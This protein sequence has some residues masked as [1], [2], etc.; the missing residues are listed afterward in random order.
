M[1]IYIAGN[2]NDALTIN[3]NINVNTRKGSAAGL[4]TDRGDYNRIIFT[5]NPIAS[6]ANNM[7]NSEIIGIV[8]RNTWNNTINYRFNNNETGMQFANASPNN[9]R[10]MVGFFVIPEILPTKIGTWTE[11]ATAP[12][13]NNDDREILHRLIEIVVEDDN[14]T[15]SSTIFNIAGNSLQFKYT[16]NDRTY[17]PAYPS[18]K[19]IRIFEGYGNTSTQPP[20]ALTPYIDEEQINSYY[21][22]QLNSVTSIG[23]TPANANS[24]DIAEASQIIIAQNTVGKITSVRNGRWSDPQTWDAGSQ[25]TILDTAVI[26]HAIWTGD[27]L[28]YIAGT[29]SRI[30]DR[31]EHDVIGSENGITKLVAVT[32]LENNGVLFIGNS[33]GSGANNINA[34]SGINN[35]IYDFGIIINENTLTS[36]NLGDI[37]ELSN[38]GTDLTGF[39]G[40]YITEGSKLNNIFRA[41]NVSNSG[42]IVNYGILEIGKE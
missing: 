18:T 38:T 28:G 15:Q 5:R 7:N 10:E 9:N 13:I 1:A 23:G 6:C 26:R 8:A 25:P 20:M 24:N 22:A 21:V 34:T 11:S 32:R 35:S 19:Q 41:I 3:N 12:N 2:V 4:I 29:N 14:R 27:G 42:N 16:N 36:A 31:A 39:H 40:I 37:N 33:R 17:F 30:W